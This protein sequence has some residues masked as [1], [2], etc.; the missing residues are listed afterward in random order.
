[1]LERVPYEMEKL[2]TPK[3][4]NNYISLNIIQFTKPN[5]RDEKTPKR[6]SEE[7]RKASKD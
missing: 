1:M 7:N 6:K 2:K 3:K 5:E 4:E